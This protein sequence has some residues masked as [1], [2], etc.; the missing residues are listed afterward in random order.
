MRRQRRMSAIGVED[1]IEASEQRLVRRHA[2]EPAPGE[3]VHHERRDAH[4][5]EDLRPELLACAGASRTMHEHD[6]G[7]PPRGALRQ[8]QLAGYDN[9]LG[10]ALVAGQELLIRE[11]ERFDRPHLGASREFLYRRIGDRGL[12]RHQRRHER[13]RQ[14]RRCEA[15]SHESL[16]AL[17]CPVRLLDATKSK[18]DRAQKAVVAAGASVPVPT[19]VS[20]CSTRSYERRNQRDTS[21]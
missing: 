11:H 19:F 4:L 15:V 20:L 10:G 12:H 14:A 8:A 2:G 3:A 13:K 18:A 1:H 21:N 6:G 5:V 7:Q 17:R 16:P 9:G